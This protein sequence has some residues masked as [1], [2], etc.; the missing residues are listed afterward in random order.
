[1][2]NNAISI[3][4]VDDEEPYREVLN[5]LLIAAGYSTTLASDGVEAINILQKKSFDAAL[6]DVQMPRVNGLEVLEFIKD[7]YLDMQTIMVT[8]VNDVSIAVKC[9]QLGAY[10]Y[11]TKPYNTSELLAVV[12]RAVERK[13][14]RKSVV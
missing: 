7:H 12:E 3:L 2:P 9:M 4:I 13:K 8:A 10:T 11:I 6:L 14:D 5:H 1:M